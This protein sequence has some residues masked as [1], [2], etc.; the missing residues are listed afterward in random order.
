MEF[1]SQ[2]SDHRCPQ[3]RGWPKSGG[4]GRR[5]A[6]APPT[7]ATRTSPLGMAQYSKRGC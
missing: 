6:G 1:A 4:H 7:T 2:E 3:P 5:G